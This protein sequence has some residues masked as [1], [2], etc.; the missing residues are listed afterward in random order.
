MHFLVQRFAKNLLEIADTLSMLSV[1][2]RRS[3][4][5]LV[6][7]LDQIP[8]DEDPPEAL[9]LL[10]LLLEGVE[11]TEKQLSKVYVSLIHSEQNR[12]LVEKS[13]FFY[14][15]FREQFYIVFIITNLGS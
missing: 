12:W 5:E 1:F 3:Y 13:V 14:F 9:L 6:P 8:E 11:M 2:V 7:S 10:E 4:A 15:F